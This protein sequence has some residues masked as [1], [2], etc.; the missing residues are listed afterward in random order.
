MMA[1]R[2]NGSRP[3][4]RGGAAVEMDFVFGLLELPSAPGE[5]ELHEAYHQV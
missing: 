2:T 3:N 4:G 5:F 1:A